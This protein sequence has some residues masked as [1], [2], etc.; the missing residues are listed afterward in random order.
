MTRKLWLETARTVGIALS[1]DDKTTS[2]KSALLE[3]M[4][5]R[6]AEQDAR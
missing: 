2:P 6:A 4:A 5:L 1:A 3:R